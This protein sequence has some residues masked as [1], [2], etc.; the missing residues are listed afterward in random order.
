MCFMDH[1]PGQGQFKKFEDYMIY[2]KRVYGLK[3]GELEE[4]KQAD[5]L[6]MK[7]IVNEKNRIP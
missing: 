7:G 1:T 2:H 5:M 3:E 6:I 4:G